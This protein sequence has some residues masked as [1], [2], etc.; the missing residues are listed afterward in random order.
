MI[1]HTTE[2]GTIVKTPVKTVR[3]KFYLHD[4]SAGTNTPIFQGNEQSISLSAIGSYIGSGAK[5]ITAKIVGNQVSY[6]SQLMMVELQ[7]KTDGDWESINLG[8]YTAYTIEYNVE[9]NISTIELYD[10]MYMFSVTPYSLDDNL[11]PMTVS[12]LA[13]TIAT[14]GGMT[15]DPDF[16]DLPNADHIIPVNLW[17]TINNIT[18]RD[19][20][21]EIAQAT[22]TTA[23]SPDGVLMFNKYEEVSET[24][25]EPNILK[26]KL[27]DKWGNVNS[28]SLSRMPQNDNILVRNQ[29][30]ADANGIYEI[31]IIN[32]QIMD[33]DR[34]TMIVP[35]ATEFGVDD[36]GL[37]TPYINYYNAEITTEGHGY[38]EIGDVINVSI[39]DDTYPILVTEVALTVDGGIREVIKSVIPTDPSVNKTTSG[40]ILKTI[41]NTEIKVDKQENDITSIVSQQQ[42][43]QDYVNNNFTQIYQ[44]IDEISLSIQ[45]GGGVNQIKNSVGYSLDDDG[46]LN[47][48]AVS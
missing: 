42:V 13:A 11:F 28:V 18:Y 16:D 26:V 20:V 29:T 8:Y 39:G 10:P 9:S 33:N 45:D 38:Y 3:A 23:I 4:N 46:D 44:D 15:L 47:F 36:H 31:V 2:Y 19:V 30:N 14:S 21:T 24:I 37:L 32:N 27:G 1:S 5:K 6:L 41:W 48:W 43:Y 17:A 34:E 22:G 12:T 35:L 7:A 25:S 40:G